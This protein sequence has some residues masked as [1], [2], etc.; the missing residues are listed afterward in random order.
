MIRANQDVVHVKLKR[1]RMD[2]EKLYEIQQER[3]KLQAKVKELVAEEKA[4]IENLRTQQDTSFTYPGP[5]GYMKIVNFSEHSRKYLDQS[6]AKRLL[7]EQ[8]P[9]RE[10]TV[11]SVT[12]DYVYE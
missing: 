7:G 9:Y 4:I 2:A 6:E 8:T 10:T 1:T 3:I 5:D 11:R 12:V